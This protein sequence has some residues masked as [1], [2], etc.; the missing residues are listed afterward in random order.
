MVRPRGRVAWAGRTHGAGRRLLSPARIARLARVIWTLRGRR[1]GLRRAAALVVLIGHVWVVRGG[2]SLGM[3]VAKR[4]ALARRRRALL[5][6][7][8]HGLGSGGCI[9]AVVDRLL[10]AAAHEEEDGS[11]DDGKGADATDNTTDNGARVALLLTADAA[12]LVC[13]AAAS[14][15]S[16]CRCRRRCRCARG[17]GGRRAPR[18]RRRGAVGSCFEKGVRRVDGLTRQRRRTTPDSKRS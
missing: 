6:M 8:K 2:S 14:A 1:V 5:R 16:R 4:R 12:V 17:L 18:S 10:L 15:A 9:R 3:V 7:V 11:S 13:S